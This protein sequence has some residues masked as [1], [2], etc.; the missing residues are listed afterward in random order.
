MKKCI[1][2][3]FFNLEFTMILLLYFFC[4]LY[5]I[6]VDHFCENISNTILCDSLF[7]YIG[8]TFCFIPLLIQKKET[9]K[10]DISIRNKSELLNNSF[11]EYIYNNPYERYLEKKDI[12]YIIVLC[13]FNIIAD[14]AEFYENYY[15]DNKIS[16]EKK[17]IILK[18]N[19]YLLKL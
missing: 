13:I 16:E 6:F 7:F 14:F 1:S 8:N 12:I 17:K 3:G 5:E 2:F 4:R 11:I 9:E 18:K 15:F 19:I 10:N